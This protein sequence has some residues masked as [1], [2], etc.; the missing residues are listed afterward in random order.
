MKR[1][2][3]T[4]QALA[5]MIR[6]DDDRAIAYVLSELKRAKGN[7]TKTAEALGCSERALY[8]WRDG[9]DRLRDGFAELAMGR[10]GAALKAAKARRLK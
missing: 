7:V 2:Y 1:P 6:A 4:T 8:T 9:N 5:A 10:T 3:P